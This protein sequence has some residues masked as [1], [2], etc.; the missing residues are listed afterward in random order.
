FGRYGYDP[1][2]NYYR[3][4]N[5]RDRAWLT[6][7]RSVY[8]GRFRGDIPRPPRTLVEQNRIVQNIT[9]N[10]RTTI[11]NINITNFV[12]ATA[13]LN[14]CKSKTIAAQ[15]VPRNQL[16]EITKY[17]REVRTF[18]RERSQIES[19]LIK[20]GGAVAGTNRSAARVVNFAAPKTL[21][22]ATTT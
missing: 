8:E 6:D 17:R 20:T 21:A 16:A 1:L 12:R 10:N 18:G 4:Q 14:R 13:P 2:F 7:L 3:W 15:P 19:N 11:N 22:A 5:R 9:V